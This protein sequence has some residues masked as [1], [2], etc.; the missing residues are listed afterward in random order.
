[1]I[2]IMSRSMWQFFCSCKIIFPRHVR[3]SIQFQI[4]VI[5]SRVIYPLPIVHFICVQE[6]AVPIGTVG[7]LILLSD[8][9]SYF[10]PK[11][12]FIRELIHRNSHGLLSQKNTKNILTLVLLNP[13]IPCLCKQYRSR[14]VGFFRSQLIWIYTVLP[15]SMWIY[16]KNRNQ[17][18]WL[19]EN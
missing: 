14:S 16:C 4:K 9:C 19:A 15:L 13:D 10:F 11:E 3:L 5:F 6:S 1:M 7:V 2:S 17:V 12:G 18:T 8:S